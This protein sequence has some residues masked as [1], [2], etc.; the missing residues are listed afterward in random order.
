MTK[1][2]GEKL[3]TANEDIL[4]NDK[5]PVDRD[6]LIDW[7]EADLWRRFEKRLWGIVSIFL[8]I[9]TVA[10]IFG[11]PYYINNESN[12]IFR[13]ETVKFDEEQRHFLSLVK[14]Y[15]K[16]N[17]DY[18]SY[19]EKLRDD[20]ASALVDI[21]HFDKTGAQSSQG[22]NFNGPAELMEKIL[23][24]QN[25]TSLLDANFV[26]RELEGKV[27]TK[28]DSLELSRKEMI[29]LE[30][31]ILDAVGGT[32]ATHPFR[33]GKLQ[34]FY[35]D[36]KF[37]IV[38]LAS[39]ERALADLQQEIFQLGGDDELGRQT[40]QLEGNTVIKSIFYPLFDKYFMDNAEHLTL[41]LGGNGNIRLDEERARRLLFYYVREAGIEPESMKSIDEI[42]KKV[43]SGHR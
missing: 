31:R 6:K 16:I 13:R 26:K 25:F 34:G 28:Y 15:Y 11:I 23:L 33:D 43:A 4:A 42:S 3:K 35:D 1:P 9:V 10:G 18:L 22:F 14:A 27:P 19:R 39:Y 20:V 24:N 2:I 17:S 38:I 37:R 8:A 40:R 36:I 12:R 30:N 32:S 21:D 5:I 41:P 29:N 7:I